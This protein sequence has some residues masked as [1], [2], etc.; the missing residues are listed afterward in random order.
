LRVPH[1]HK[2][3][4]EALGVVPDLS[5]KEPHGCKK[6]HDKTR[7]CVIQAPDPTHQA[8]GAYGRHKECGHKATSRVELNLFAGQTWSE[9]VVVG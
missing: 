1:N 4:A 5:P 9:D 6:Y 8:E 2:A 7:P 3:S